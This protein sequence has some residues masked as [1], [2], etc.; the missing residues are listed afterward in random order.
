MKLELDSQTADIH[1]E[2]KL[3][4]IDKS[5]LLLSTSCLWTFRVIRFQ[6]S[7]HNQYFNLYQFINAF[8]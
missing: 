4:Y 7:T 5:T 6:L 3:L 2:N 8:N 1:I